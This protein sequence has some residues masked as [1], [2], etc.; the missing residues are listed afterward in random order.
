MATVEYGYS[1]A[2]TRNP[3]RYARAVWRLI[4]RDLET[5]TEEAAIVELGFAR[6]KLGRRFAR[7]DEVASALHRDP[8][9]V[10]A[11]QDRKPVSPIVLE[12]L[13][14][15]PVGTLGRS[16]ALHCRSRALNP[17]LV[18]IP[19]TDEVGWILHHLYQTHD[20]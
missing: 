7:W 15:L 16:F 8:R 5:T 13:E 20:I 11:I 1:A 2:P 10:A 4:T 9:T 17:N 12:D 6:S 19:P 14:V 3:L 18:Q